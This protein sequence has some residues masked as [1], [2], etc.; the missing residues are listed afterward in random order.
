MHFD[1]NEE[2][3]DISFIS[4]QRL[5]LLLRSGDFWIMMLFAALFA[6][7]SSH[8]GAFETFEYSCGYG[9][10]DQNYLLENPFASV[11]ITPYMMARIVDISFVL[12]NYPFKKR[13]AAFALQIEE[14]HYAKWNEGIV[15]VTIENG[16]II[17]QK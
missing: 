17:S 3:T 2:A 8:N 5:P 10:N 13:Q 7:V 4:L 6:S 15:E 14:D 16:K 11:M 12:E 1:D 9:G